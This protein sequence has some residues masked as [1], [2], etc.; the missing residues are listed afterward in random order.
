VGSPCEFDSIAGVSGIVKASSSEQDLGASGN[1]QFFVDHILKQSEQLQHMQQQAEE[2]RSCQMDLELVRLQLNEKTKLQERL[3]PALMVANDALRRLRNEHMQLSR[4]ARASGV[5]A[6]ADTRR[7][8][9]ALLDRACGSWIG[10]G[11][12][13]DFAFQSTT[14]RVQEAEKEDRRSI[15]SSPTPSVASKPAS[16][17]S[18]RSWSQ[19]QFFPDSSEQTLGAQLSIAEQARRESAL[20]IAMVRAQAASQARQLAALRADEERAHAA[21]L[22][23]TTSD[24]IEAVCSARAALTEQ[25]EQAA[26]RERLLMDRL[27]KREAS[28]QAQRTALVKEL[29]AA[30]AAQ[31][32]AVEEAEARSASL[33]SRL[34]RAELDIARSRIGESVGFGFREKATSSDFTTLV[35]GGD[36]GDQADQGPVTNLTNP[37]KGT[38]RSRER[39]RR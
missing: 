34:A 23:R 37:S 13:E 2:L 8:I 30:R 28:D 22:A 33:E 17:F 19:P 15:P 25:A 16:L 5:A 27:Q 9:R 12:R 10:N 38:T 18:S 31:Q 26:E 4:L 21:E 14:P 35:F 1:R 6:Q 32:L 20:T 11:S 39:G 36:E 29:E 3:V 7:V 24:C